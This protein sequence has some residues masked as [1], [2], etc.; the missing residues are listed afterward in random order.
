M[1]WAETALDLFGT[2]THLRKTHLEAYINI[3][4]MYLN[5]AFLKQ[6]WFR[7]EPVLREARKM[8]S[9]NQPAWLRTRL[10]QLL[11]FW[12]F[13]YWGNTKLFAGLEPGEIEQRTDLV[14]DMEDA[15]HSNRVLAIYYTAG[16]L[17]FFRGQYVVADFWWEYIP[18]SKAFE[19]RADIKRSTAIL[20]LLTKYEI[21]GKYEPS[22]LHQI[23]AVRKRLDHWGHIM[24]HE[25]LIING[26]KKII[27]TPDLT[28]EQAAMWDLAHKLLAIRKQHPNAR[29]MALDETL[30]W[31]GT[32]LDDLDTDFI[33][34]TIDP[35]T[36]PVA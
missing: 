15:F 18:T 23:D 32:K 22:L 24:D 12:E 33:F 6:D 17:H 35:T 8:L 16:I 14:N 9:K 13:S 4:D 5:T 26:L 28:S 11:I 30:Y 25:R 31:L 27:N 1:E 10:H 36:P 21:E 34:G 7:F 3:L 2:S 20:R 19:R 29:L